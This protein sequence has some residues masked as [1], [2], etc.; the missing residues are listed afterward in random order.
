M[1]E[2]LED[3]WQRALA[4]KTQTHSNQELSTINMI[5]QFGNTLSCSRAVMVFKERNNR[6]SYF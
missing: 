3:F 2:I 6:E 5:T 4:R 1:T